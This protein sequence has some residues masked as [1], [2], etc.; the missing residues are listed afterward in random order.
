MYTA[1]KQRQTVAFFTGRPRNALILTEESTVDL[2]NAGAGKSGAPFVCDPYP[3]Y[4]S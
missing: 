1:R 3:M 2:G 4:S